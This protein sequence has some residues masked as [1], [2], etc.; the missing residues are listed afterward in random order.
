[1]ISDDDMIED[2]EEN[3]ENKENDLTQSENED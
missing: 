2:E 3:S 1:M